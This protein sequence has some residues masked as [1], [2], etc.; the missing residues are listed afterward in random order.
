MTGSNT[1]H[2]PGREHE[3]VVE[4]LAQ[5]GSDHG[6][7]GGIGTD[8]VPEVEVRQPGLT[9]VVGRD[10]RAGQITRG[11]AGLRHRQDGVE[12][13]APLQILVLLACRRFLHRPSRCARSPSSTLVG[14]ADIGPQHV[15]PGQ[16]AFGG[17]SGNARS[18]V[19][20]H[21]G[22]CPRV[23]HHLP[24]GFDHVGR[25][26]RVRT[27]GGRTAPTG[28][29]GGHRGRATV[30]VGD[31]RFGDATCLSDSRRSGRP[32]SPVWRD[33]STR[34]ASR[35][36]RRETG[37]PPPAASHR[38]ARRPRPPPPTGMS[39]DDPAEMLDAFVEFEV[40]RRR[41]RGRRAPPSRRTHLPGTAGT[42]A[43]Q[44]RR[45][46]RWRPDARRGTGRRRAA[47][48]GT[49]RVHDVAVAQ[50]HQRVDTLDPHGFPQPRTASRGTSAITIGQ[51]GDAE[52]ARGRST[53]QR[54]SSA[55]IPGTSA[56]WC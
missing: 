21:T 18:P 56:R 1:K 19:V 11:R 43:V 10:R 28:P 13:V 49:R 38:S 47:A 45:P 53:W 20:V 8:A 52:L 16:L 7:F 17:S 55:P 50:Q 32:S 23:G 15:T 27:R 5:I 46:G 37:D 26:H 35:A 30:D 14:D 4:L 54:W 42:G 33:R 6:H 9:S 48:S 2:H 44:R 39:D 12:D 24:D 51:I 36:G 25:W 3:V 29:S 31:R 41:G 34:A 22:R 40:E